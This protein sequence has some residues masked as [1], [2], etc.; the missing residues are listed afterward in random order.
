[1]KALSV[2]PRWAMMILTGSKTIETRTWRTKYRG[3]ILIVTSKIPVIPG[4]PSGHAICIAR[5]IDCRPMIKADEKAACCEIYRN[6]FAWILDNI[7]PIE[8]FP[9]KGQ[10]GIFEVKYENYIML[11]RTSI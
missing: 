3:D 6:A 7:R 1:M 4:I 11:Q 5:I 2:K 10:L 8:P 9:V